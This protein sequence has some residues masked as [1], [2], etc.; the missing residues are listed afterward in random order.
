[1]GELLVRHAAVLYG[2]AYFGSIALAAAWEGLA[3][4]RALSGPLRARWLAHF[5]LGV[6]DPL[7]V[8]AALPMLDVAVAIAAAE[9]GFGLFHHVQL[10]GWLAGLV[11]ILVLDLTRY[12]QHRLLHRVPLLWR[13]HRAHH[14]D[15]D[16]DFTTA[17]RF[18]PFESLLTGSIG[19]ASV[20]VLGAPV[21]AVVL[22]ECLFV[23]SALF[24]HSNA[25]IPRSLD[26][27]LRLAVVT[28]DLHRVHHS[29]RERE[30]QS[31]YGSL[32]PWWDRVLGTYRPDPVDGHATMT[33]GLQG[34][35]EPR[36]RTLL[37]MLAN[38]FLPP[39]RSST[40]SPMGPRRGV[41]REEA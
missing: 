22:N 9:R 36:H 28:P 41:A 31:N 1:M 25:R 12:G 8:R 15:V 3:P 11:S 35:G 32:L 7:V 10:P 20:A 37:G 34:F 27:V 19:V 30:M 29:A 13:L 6:I 23:T 38:P 24:A 18:H 14:T 33:L 4:R 26:R 5:A 39:T 2:C 21:A 40:K 17:L 16:Y